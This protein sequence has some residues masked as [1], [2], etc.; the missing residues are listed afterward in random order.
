MKK[1]MTTSDHGIE[2]IKK[3]E[4]LRLNSYLCP[5]GVPTIGYGHTSGVNLNERITIEQADDFLRSDIKTT[6]NAVN[7]YQLDLTQNQFDAI[8]SFVYN[9]GV[10]NFKS[11]TLLKRL[12][13][14]TRHPDIHQQFMRWVFGGGKRLSGLYNRRV[15]EWLLFNKQ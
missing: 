14:N 3:H 13:E 5:A 8:V 9:V 2:M 10:P 11:S 6:E 4:S 15:Q 1:E 12:K 7:S